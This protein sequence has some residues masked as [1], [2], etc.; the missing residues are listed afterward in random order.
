MML[1]KSFLGIDIYTQNMSE[2]LK[3][4][5]VGMLGIF[6]VIGIIILVTMLINKV[7]S[8]KK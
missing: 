8:G 5:I 2:S 6:A 7:F 3:F 4:L 1:L